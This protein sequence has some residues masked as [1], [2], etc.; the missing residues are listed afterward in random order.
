MKNFQDFELTQDEQRNAIGKGKPEWAGMK[1]GKKA[2]EDGSFTPGGKRKG[3]G[4]KPWEK[5]DMI[6]EDWIAMKE[7]QEALEGD[8]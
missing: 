4:M 1:G 5:L 2:F 8:E 6:K 3:K 7:E